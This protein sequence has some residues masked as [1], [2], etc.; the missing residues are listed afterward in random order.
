MNFWSCGPL[1]KEPRGERLPVGLTPSDG[2]RCSGFGR[3]VKV[4]EIRVKADVVLRFL[5]DEKLRT[6]C[7][8]FSD[9][10]V[11]KS[12]RNGDTVVRRLPGSTGEAG[13]IV[14]EIEEA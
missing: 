8:V 5:V 2:I 6:V 12:Q 14:V 4:R 3:Y 7:A 10:R 11:C 1:F 13:E 9:F